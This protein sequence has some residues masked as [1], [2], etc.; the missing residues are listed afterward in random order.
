MVRLKKKKIFVKLIL[1][2]EFMTNINTNKLVETIKR[3][4]YSNDLIYN[5][6]LRIKSDATPDFINKI[7]TRNGLELEYVESPSKELCKKAIK[8][9]IYAYVFIKDPK[10]KEELIGDVLRKD[11]MLLEFVEN[12]NPSKDLCEIALGNNGLA[13]QFIT[14][15]PEKY[16]ETAID[17][18]PFSLQYIENQSDELCERAVRK[19]SDALQ[20][21]KNQTEN[22]IM[23]A[24]RNS[25][26]SFVHVKDKTD[27]L[28]MKIL[29][30]ITEYNLNKYAIPVLL[31][32]VPH[33]D[34]FLYKK[35]IEINPYS[36]EYIENQTEELVL[37]AFDTFTKNKD[38][39]H[40]VPPKRE[41]KYMRDLCYENLRQKRNHDDDYRVNTMQKYKDQL[42]ER[43]LQDDETGFNTTFLS[44]DQW[45]KVWTP[46]IVRKRFTLFQAPATTLILDV[47]KNNNF[48][49]KDQKEIILAKVA[50]KTLISDFKLLIRYWK[51]NIDSNTDELL[52]KM[53]K[54]FGFFEFI[55]VE[56]ENGLVDNIPEIV[57]QLA[58]K[59]NGLNLKYVR[60]QNEDLCKIAIE[61]NP[62]AL[63]FVNNRTRELCDI[64]VEKYIDEIEKENALKDVEVINDEKE[65]GGILDT[66]LGFFGSGS[67]KG[68]SKH[69]TD[70]LCERR[71]YKSYE[72]IPR[73]SRDLSFL[74][75][76]ENTTPEKIEKLVRLD[77]MIIKHLKK[78]TNNMCELAVQQNGLSL[79]FVKNKTDRICELA[80]EN[81]HKS[82]YFVDCPTEKIIDIY[83]RKVEEEKTKRPK[84]EPFYNKECTV[85]PLEENMFQ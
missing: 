45:I 55:I 65:G 83:E 74:E 4:Y 78:Q 36:L 49:Q 39:T 72:C 21:V 60:N 59:E 66:V 73:K 8:Q 52:E 19:N 80:V 33:P 10:L 35:F 24:I 46:E 23:T 44:I 71:D 54:K 28:I 85:K 29:D 7:V 50:E 18:N 16:Y 5:S 1:Y 13:I 34:E 76:A 41:D 20:F 31:K 51:T 26:D 56:K 58:L 32:Y 37:A 15:N 38:I 70:C 2:I 12:G 47:M 3:K 42:K 68:E 40:I 62:I 61:Q 17:Q 27:D 6:Y 43:K 77:G 53:A 84:Y 69:R 9:H 67:K 25:L 30:K 14:E 57:Y 48:E 64:V 81:N 75:Y 63:E 82:M 79:E 22:I 11:G